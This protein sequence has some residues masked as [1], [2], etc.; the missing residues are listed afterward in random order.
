MV[1]RKLRAARLDPTV[2]AGLA[3]ARKDT[4]ARAGQPHT[5][6]D[7]DIAYQ[8]YDQRDIK[9]EAL[10]AQA[11]LG[12]LDKLG[13]LLKQQHDRTPGRDELKRLVTSIKDETTLPQEKTP[14]PKPHARR[15]RSSGDSP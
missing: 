9:E 12:S 14:F 2:L 15:T 7:L 4:T 11:L 1:D 6:R 3:V 10:C 5:A 13:L 8:P